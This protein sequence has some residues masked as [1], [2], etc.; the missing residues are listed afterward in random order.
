[1]LLGGIPLNDADWVEWCD[2]KAS[3]PVEVVRKW[4]RNVPDYKYVPGDPGKWERN[5]EGAE[6]FSTY[7]G[8]FA[9]CPF[10]WQFVKL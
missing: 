5:T 7:G 3:A 6:T 2:G 4:R 10:N 1:M 8:R 9:K